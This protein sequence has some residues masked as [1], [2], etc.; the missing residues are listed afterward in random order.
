M[1]ARQQMGKKQPTVTQE[2]AQEQEG[3]QREDGGMR[4]KK[5]LERMDEDCSGSSGVETAVKAICQQWRNRLIMRKMMKWMMAK[6]QTTM[7][8]TNYFTT[9]FQLVQI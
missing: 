5:K 9:E 3:N 4:L 7:E 6:L 2:D 8:I 1:N